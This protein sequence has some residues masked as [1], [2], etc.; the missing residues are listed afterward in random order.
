MPVFLS[1]SEFGA[2]MPIVVKL[3]PGLFLFRGMVHV[4]C[5]EI[6]LPVCGACPE[7]GEIAAA[8]LNSIIVL[9]F[10]VARGLLTQKLERWGLLVAGFAHRAYVLPYEC[11]WI[12]WDILA[13]SLLL[14]GPYGMGFRSCR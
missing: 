12:P 13:T 1:H 14:P 9:N 10:F 11:V 7:L 3:S 2:C 6:A 5:G 4:H 8:F